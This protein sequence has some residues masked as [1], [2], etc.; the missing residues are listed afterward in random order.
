MQ[1]HGSQSLACPGG[2]AAEAAQLS[3]ILWGMALCALTDGSIER[4]VVG[5][6]PLWAVVAI[7]RPALLPFAP[8]KPASAGVASEK[9][10]WQPSTPPRVPAA[11]AQAAIVMVAS[12]HVAHRAR[13]GLAR[14]RPSGQQLRQYGSV[15]GAP[16]GACARLK[17]PP[18]CSARCGLSL[19]RDSVAPA[20]SGVD[21]GAWRRAT[22]P[23]PA[24]TQV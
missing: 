21:G 5:S 19:S 2:R 16:T 12:C 17:A 10:G 7:A 24:R 4:A 15:V 23:L 3:A 22:P 6:E 20:V 13:R 11:E 8:R 1:D 9:A 14:M 18:G